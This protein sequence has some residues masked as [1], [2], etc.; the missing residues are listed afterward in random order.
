MARGGFGILSGGYA[1]LLEGS[2]VRVK[3]AVERLNPV[4]RFGMANLLS[5]PLSL[6]VINEYPKS[7]GS[8]LGQMLERALGLPYPRNRF[9][10]FRASI[11]HGH[12]LHLM[13]GTSLR[14]RGAKNVLVVWRDGRDVMVSSYHHSLF[15]NER[16]NGRLVEMTRKELDFPDYEDVRANLPRFV[17]Y[18]FTRQRYPRFSWADFARRWNGRKGVVHT[19]YEILRHDT[20]GELAR[21]A[22]DLTGRELSL[23]RAREVAE[24]FSFERQSGGRKPGQENKGSFV[25][26]GIVGD[27]RTQFTQEAR[28]VFDRYAG[29]ELIRLGYEPN[30]SWVS[31][32]G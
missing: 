14:P 16:S 5:G 4:V 26:K 9:P 17:E 2:V 1:A 18:A 31:E 24:E 29:D 7:G 19:S 22:R 15:K 8:W 32:D 28:E 10:E 23:E 27:W 20:A 30:R 13:D 25:R 12:Y 6:Y 11:M 21:I 3:P